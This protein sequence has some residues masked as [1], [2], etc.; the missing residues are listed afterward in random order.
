MDPPYCD[1]H[2]AVSDITREQEDV[3]GALRNEMAQTGGFISLCSSIAT[4]IICIGH[5]WPRAV[6]LHF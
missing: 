3:A 5:P 4:E 6:Y 2:C 1:W